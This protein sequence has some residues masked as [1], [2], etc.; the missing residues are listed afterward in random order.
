MTLTAKQEAFAQAVASGMSQ[1]DAYRAAYE[2]SPDTK[3]DTINQKG[4]R[5]MAEGKIKARVEEL[6][7][8]V[9]KAAQI[10]L[11]GH[12][13][14]LGELSRLSQ[15]SGQMSAAIAAE[16]ARGKASG[17]YVERTEITGSVAVQAT[18]V[19]EG[20][21]TSALAEI[22]AAADAAKRN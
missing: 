6:R 12:L 18:L 19:V 20:L 14:R 9:V 15:E 16:V 21:S 5:L 2:V 4:S 22:M 3:A 10:T 8:P 11:A 7:A 13:E 17:L 1:S